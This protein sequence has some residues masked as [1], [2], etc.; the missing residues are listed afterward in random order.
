MVLL[1]LT[2]FLIIFNWYNFVLAMLTGRVLQS[3]L[4]YFLNPLITVALGLFLLREH[5]N[6]PQKVSLG[7]A[8]LGVALMVVQTGEVPTLAL[9]L[10]FSFA[11]YGYFKKRMKVSGALS[12]LIETGMGT[13]LVLVPLI[14]YGH[15]DYSPSTWALLILAGPV[16]AVPLIWFAWGVQRLSMASAGFL[17]FTTPIIQ[18]ALAVYCYGEPFDNAKRLSFSVIWVALAIF[19]GD[20][21]RRLQRK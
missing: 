13:P 17:Q 19:C 15:W 2:S 12:L 7:L 20:L 6:W 10:A 8:T 1:A 16:T 18:F 21:A 9:I 14:L 11:F 4:A 3:S 5:L